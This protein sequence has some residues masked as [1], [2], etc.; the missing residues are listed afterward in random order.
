[1][2]FGKYYG[3]H[4]VQN[5]PIDSL[6]SLKKRSLSPFSVYLR[7][8]SDMVRVTYHAWGLLALY[9]HHEVRDMHGELCVRLEMKLIKEDSWLFCF[10]FAFSF[11]RDTRRFN[12]HLQEFV[13][14]RTNKSGDSSDGGGTAAA[15]TATGILP[16]QDQRK[17]YGNYGKRVPLIL[18]VT[19]GLPALHLSY[20]HQ[21][22]HNIFM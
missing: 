21:K 3:S 11:T 6:V 1:M 9:R 17:Y 22:R 4:F 15:A 2:L 20:T 18:E 8:Q 19:D 7:C 13:N 12:S 5:D 16:P 10:L 14:K